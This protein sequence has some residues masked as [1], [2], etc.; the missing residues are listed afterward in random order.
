MNGSHRYE[1]LDG[2]RGICALFVCILHARILSDFFYL[3]LIRNSYLFVDFFFVLS[4]FVICS[5]FK[6]GQ[7]VIYIIQFIIKRIGRIWPLHM[8]MIVL[9]IIIEVAKFLVLS[10]IHID[11]SSSVFEGRFSIESLLSN[12]FLI[13][14]LGIHDALTWNGP[15]WSISVEFVSYVI[16]AIIMTFLSNIT[17]IISFI[18]FTLSLLILMGSNLDNIDVTYDYGVFRCFC[19]FFIGVFI[20]KVRSAS[21]KLNGNIASFL[22]II[23]VIAIGI[24]I[25]Y[26]GDNT[27]S[28]VSPMVFGF[29]V[30]FYSYEL[31]CISLF[32]RTKPLQFLGKISFTIYMIHSVILTFLWRVIYLLDAGRNIYIVDSGIEDGYKKIIN[33]GGEMTGNLLIVCYLTTVI[34]LSVMIYNHYENPARK[35]FYK[36]SDKI[37]RI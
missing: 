7:G 27:L 30:W 24:F 4:G 10:N 26:S 13:H 37:K 15:S 20:Y 6:N 35:I 11:S 19:G 16:F 33:I 14:A 28:L 32:L 12:I 3:E 5:S 9:L 18:I 23:M 29:A 31:G 1:S 34:A 25:I 22:E 21:F 17:K 8:L 2:L 36:Y